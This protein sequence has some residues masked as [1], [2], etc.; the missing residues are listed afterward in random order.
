M[1]IV[2]IEVNKLFGVFD[3]SIPLMTEQ[4][5]TIVIGEN[6]LGKTVILEAINSFFSGEYSFFYDLDFESF[7]FHF[8]NNEIWQLTKKHGK[9]P[10]L[11]VGRTTVDKFGQK[12]KAHKISTRDYT[13]D[14]SNRFRMME[15][16]QRELEFMRYKMNRER[17]DLDELALL[18]G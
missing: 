16:R 9:G 6:G 15:R 8:D 12:I 1:K 7:Y 11:F 3:H 5:I 17:I 13:G 14:K 4:N 2:K 10:A 18:S